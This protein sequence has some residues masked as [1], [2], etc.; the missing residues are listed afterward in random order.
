MIVSNALL[1]SDIYANDKNIWR[2]YQ[3]LGHIQA[4]TPVICIFE[5]SFKCHASLRHFLQWQAYLMIVSNASLHSGIYTYDKNIWRLYQMP[6]YTEAFPPMIGI[7]DDCF[8]CQTSF[9]SFHQW[10][11][12]LMIVLNTLLHSGIYTNDKSIWTLFQNSI[13][14]NN[15]CAHHLPC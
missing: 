12:Y 13:T 1:H 15:I 7:F 8:K 11:A 14:H 5:T 3:F 4:F 2:L 10:Q 9:K 6:F